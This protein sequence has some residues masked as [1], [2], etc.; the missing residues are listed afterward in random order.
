MEKK[1]INIV[2]AIIQQ[3]GKI[4]CAKRLRKGPPYIA[5]HWEFPGGKIEE[6][7][8]PKQALLREIKEELDWNISVDKEIGEIIY[9]YPDFTVHLTALACTANNNDY[10][11][12]EHLDAKWLL[13]ENL[14]ILEWTAADKQ[15]I[16]EL[17]LNVK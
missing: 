5:E 7:E 15:L 16:E 10:K 1:I 8:T 17:S 14:S 3:K 9:H 4:F 6:N 13:P 2:C 11:L 12:F